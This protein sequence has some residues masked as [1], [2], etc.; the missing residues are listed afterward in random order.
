M[1]DHVNAGRLSLERF[2]DLS[3]HGPARI[4]N[5]ARKGRIA[6]GNDADLTIVDMKRRETITND[7]V[8]SKAGWTP[9][10]GVAVT[11]WPVGTVL[12]G[13]RVMWQGELVTPASGRAI[14]FLETLAPRA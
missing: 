7:W 1:L 8:A 4:F 9:Y 3:S 12:R 11:G 13:A 10:D 5:I 2:V 14:E 6:V